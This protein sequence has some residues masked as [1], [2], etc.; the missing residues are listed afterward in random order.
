[1]RRAT[2]VIVEGIVFLLAGLMYTKGIITEESNNIFI[3][4]FAI[5]YAATTIGQNGQH[6]PDI[7]KARRSGAILFDIIETKDES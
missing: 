7:A 2:I 4:L 1:M 5:I 6:M 3:A